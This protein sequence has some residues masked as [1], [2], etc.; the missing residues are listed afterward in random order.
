MIGVEKMTKPDV[1]I[2]IKIKVDCSMKD[3]LKIWLLGLANKVDAMIKKI[4]SEYK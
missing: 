2:T 4:R 1:T 3:V